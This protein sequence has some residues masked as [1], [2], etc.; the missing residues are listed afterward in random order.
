MACRSVPRPRA[1]RPA[2]AGAR[3]R[4]RSIR[5]IATQAR[6]S[7]PSRLSLACEGVPRDSGG[8]EFVDEGRM[9]ATN[10]SVGCSCQ[11]AR[12]AHNTHPPAV[13]PL[14]LM[15]NNSKNSA[16]LPVHSTR[17]RGTTRS[18][19]NFSE[20]PPATCF[21]SRSGGQLV[22]IALRF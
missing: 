21:T 6:R 14:R 13:R 3:V 4:G 7:K 15:G 16:P 10:S 22:W 8:R 17:G 5:P 2:G 18:R 20:W 9:A 12:R 19:Q 1:A 11:C